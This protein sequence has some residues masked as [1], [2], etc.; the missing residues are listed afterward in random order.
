MLCVHVQRVCYHLEL[1]HICTAYGFEAPF[2][3]GSLGQGVGEGEEVISWG[4]SL[5]HILS[6]LWA[7]YYPCWKKDVRSHVDSGSLCL[8]SSP[9][10]SVSVSACL[11]LSPHPRWY[12]M[13]LNG[14]KQCVNEDQQSDSES[15]RFS[16]SMASPSDYEC[17]R[18]SFT[19]DFSSK[20]S[21][22]AC[23]QQGARWGWRGCWHC[24]MALESHKCWEQITHFPS[25]LY[26]LD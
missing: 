24:M 19:S 25:F 20:S 16:Q 5:F 11:S 14:E 8:S 26:A 12:K 7:L 4:L 13:P 21:S 1:L 2:V 3:E 10:L 23:K 15:S 18:Q 6:H 22:P 9:H 17:S